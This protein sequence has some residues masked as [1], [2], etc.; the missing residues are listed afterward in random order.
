MGHAFL[1]GSFNN[2][3]LTTINADSGVVGT[4]DQKGAI[5]PPPSVVGVWSFGCV[6]ACV[7]AKEVLTGCSANMAGKHWGHHG[8]MISR[9]LSKHCH[10]RWVLHKRTC[11]TEWTS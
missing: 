11:A 4:N 9:W 10:V 5:F 8:V 2:D 3:L 1:S 7:S 6:R